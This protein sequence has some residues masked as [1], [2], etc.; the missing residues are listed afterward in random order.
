MKIALLMILCSTV[1]NTCLNPAHV[2]TYDDNFNCMLNGHKEA[3][4]KIEEMGQYQI[5]EYGI[6]IKFKCQEIQTEES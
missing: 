1:A 6:F 5:N 4:N 2:K 3:I